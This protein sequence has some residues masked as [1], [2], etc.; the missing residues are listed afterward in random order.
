MS[1]GPLPRARLLQIG[2]LVGIAP[3]H[4]RV[5]GNHYAV[6]K[7]AGGYELGDR[8]AARFDSLHA[9][10]LHL[11]RLVARRL[12]LPAGRLLVHGAAVVRAGAAWLLLGPGWSGKSTLTLE[13]WLRGV[14]V[15]GDDMLLLDPL[16]GTVEAMPKPMKVRLAAARV[17]DRL[18]HVPAR[19]RAMGSAGQEREKLILLG[20]GLPGMAA[21]GRPVPLGGAFLLRRHAGPGW[22]TEPVAKPALVEAVLGE[23]RARPEA[24]LLALK[25]FFLLLREGAVQ[26]LVVGE[27]AAG[28]A[29]SVLEAP[30]GGAATPSPLSAGRLCA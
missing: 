25:P 5:A 28:E 7:V 23:V 30:A 2:R 18:K 26:A 11:A 12:P 8:Q 16:A 4:G 22:W 10:S 14:E 20:R 21:L 3:T 17:P 24:R 9:L 13:A 19:H 15:I 1:I 6:S 29:A 27:G